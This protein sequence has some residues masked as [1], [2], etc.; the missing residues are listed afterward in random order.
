MKNDLV[1]LLGTQGLFLCTDRTHCTSSKSHKSC[2]DDEMYGEKVGEK[3]E[4]KGRVK[5]RENWME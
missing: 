3:E 2:P 5:T 4:E 1:Y